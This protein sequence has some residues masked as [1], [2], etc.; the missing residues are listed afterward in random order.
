M[1]TMCSYGFEMLNKLGVAQMLET[2][3][4]TIHGSRVCIMQLFRDIEQCY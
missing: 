2:V 3:T 4:T 1:A